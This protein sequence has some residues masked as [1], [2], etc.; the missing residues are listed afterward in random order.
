MNKYDVIIIGAGPAG[1]FAALEL[2][3]EKPE[4]S[5]LMLE[6]GNAIEKRICPKR[7]TGVCVGCKPCNITTGLPER[8]L[9]QTGSSRCRR[10][11]A[12]SCR[13]ISVMKKPKNLSPMW[14]SIICVLGQIPRYMVSIIRRKSAR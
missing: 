14:M 5:I 6:K 7:K 13:I 10:M 3:K 12:E 9:T 1:I 11:S 4:L 8:A 2:K